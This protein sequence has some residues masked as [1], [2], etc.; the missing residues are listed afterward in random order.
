MSIA[1]WP[2]CVFDSAGQISAHSVQ[3]VQSSGESWIVYLFP[4]Y[5]AL[6]STAL[7]LSGAPW[8]ASGG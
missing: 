7:K 6:K 3:P 8:S 4:F 1:L 2:F 5:G